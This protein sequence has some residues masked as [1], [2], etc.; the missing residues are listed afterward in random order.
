MTMSMNLPFEGTFSP[1]L[2][3]T[4]L[5]LG[6][7]A[8]ALR[9]SEHGVARMRALGMPLLYWA[10]L[11]ALAMVQQRRKKMFIRDFR[12]IRLRRHVLRRLQRLLHLL[13]VFVDAHLFKNNQGAAVSKPPFT[14][15]QC[16]RAG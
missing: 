3:Y 12:I 8:E 6:A 7:Y 10:A 16:R 2:A 15:R 1:N 5:D 11:D 14:S 4:L 9:A 13:R